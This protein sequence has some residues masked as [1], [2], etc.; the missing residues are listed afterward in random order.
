[1]RFRFASL[2]LSLVTAFSAKVGVA[3]SAD[4]FGKIRQEYVRQLKPLQKEAK[5]A[6]WAASLSGSEADFKRKQEAELAL[7]KLHGDRVVF[8]RLK[9]IRSGAKL[10]D[11]LQARELEIMYRS[12][13]ARQGDS[14]LHKRIVELENEVERTFNTHR[15][16]IGKRS[17]SE[18][19]IRAILRYESST[20]S[21]KDAWMAYVSVG[22]KVESQ[23]RQLVGL[24]NQIAAQSGFA[25]YYDM[26]LFCDELNTDELFELFDQLNALTEDE[27]RRIKSEVDR[28]MAARFGVEIDGLRPWHY[29]DIFFQNA[30]NARTVDLDSIFVN[31]DLIKLSEEY[32]ESMGLPCDKIL[33]R[34]DLHERPGKSPHAFCTDIDRE[35]DVRVLCNMRSDLYWADTLF[36]E[37]GHAVYDQYIDEGLPYLLRKAA[38]S[39]TTEGVALMMGAMVKNEDWL[40][41]GLRL[42]REQAA[43]TARAAHEALRVEKV[44]FS[45]WAQVMVR[46][47][48]Q[49]YSAPEQ[50]LSKLWWELKRRYQCLT[51][52]DDTSIPGYA[53]KVHI[54]LWPVYYHGYM[55]GD[56][57]AAQLHACLVRDVVRGVDVSQESFYGR[58]DVGDFLKKRLFSPGASWPWRELTEKVTGEPL[59]ARYFAEQF[60]KEAENRQE[61]Q[62]GG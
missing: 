58:R 43:A 19:E 7:A 1:M 24:R 15:G 5:L 38:H 61:R 48:Q 10:E 41:D 40:R 32:Y 44:V 31:V 26:M 4:E 9:A 20:S 29:G 51:P 60:L 52:P 45:R 35:G 27:Y 28:Q 8:E 37:L 46:F 11:S 33:A 59:S 18:N 42:S 54:L 21:V 49:M 56:L 6:A 39:T 25:N 62:S 14:S 36:H 34:S 50:D 22:E 57:F 23:L 2:C 47:E 53:A 16:V 3:D 13:L 12:F 30:P 17:L 55:L